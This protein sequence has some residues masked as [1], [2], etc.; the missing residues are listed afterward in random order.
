[1]SFKVAVCSIQF[2]GSCTIVVCSRDS[3]QLKHL[4]TLLHSRYTAEHCSIADGIQ[5]IT[6]WDAFLHHP[7]C[8][9]L[10]Q[11]YYA[12]CMSRQHAQA[13]KGRDRLARHSTV[14]CAEAK[15]QYSCLECGNV[16][17]KMTPIP[18]Y[19]PTNSNCRRIPVMVEHKSILMCARAL[20][21]LGECSHVVPEML[22]R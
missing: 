7:Y 11:P 20:M 9:R 19:A 12:Q 6:C 15:K 17:Y 4:L 18:S 10:V 13:A 16:P 14:A 5:C 8:T 21:I 3:K 2:A 1:M 22:R